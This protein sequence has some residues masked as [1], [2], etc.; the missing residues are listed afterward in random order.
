MFKKVWIS[1]EPAQNCKAAYHKEDITM[2]IKNAK[3]RFSIFIQVIITLVLIG[4]CASSGPL[5]NLENDH[6]AQEQGFQSLVFWRI[7][8]IDRTNSFGK[9]KLANVPGFQFYEAEKSVSD[10]ILH[11]IRPNLKM[12]AWD[13]KVLS[14]GWVKKDDVSYLDETTIAEIKP[15]EYTLDNIYFLME[16]YNSYTVGQGGTT[17]TNYF[18]ID[19]DKTYDIPPGKLL[20][21]GEFDVEFVSKKNVE[22]KGNVYTYN[23]KINQNTD[24]FNRNLKI[25]QERYP[26]LYNQFKN[27][28]DI[29]YSKYLFFEDFSLTRILHSGDMSFKRSKRA[30]KDSVWELFSG[31]EYHLSGGEYIIEPNDN[32]CHWSTIKFPTPVPIN[33][34]IEL[35]STW[36]SGVENGTHGLLLANDSNNFCQFTVS[37]NG[38]SCIFVGVDGKYIEPQPVGWKPNTANKGNG[39]IANRHKVEVRGNVLNYYVNDKYIGRVNNK[40]NFKN[41][42]IGVFVC[43]KQKVAFDDL[44]IK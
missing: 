8:V 6:L 4:G 38:Y 25:V 32:K 28:V 14:G 35:V 26:L 10:P 9:P 37:G 24:D 27:N 19:V 17:A 30:W 11:F 18:T 15:G 16:H 5:K 20:Y 42:F 29:A 2:P 7:K 1:V 21:L 13:G 44:K 41:G 12:S 36:K 31:G 40:I 43:D 39:T 33:F 23:V 22:N 3:T 34:D